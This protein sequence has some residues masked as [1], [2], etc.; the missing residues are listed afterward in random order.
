M[1]PLLITALHH[2]S[3]GRAVY[4]SDELDNQ[5]R[6]NTRVSGGLG[7]VKTCRDLNIK[8]RQRR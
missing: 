7:G 1:M 8:S 3:R 6:D 2:Y 4:F 5:I